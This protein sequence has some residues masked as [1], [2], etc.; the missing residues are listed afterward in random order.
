MLYANWWDENSVDAKIELWRKRL[1]GLEVSIK[2]NK[3]NPTTK[4]VMQF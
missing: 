3:K 2:K 4:H 1:Q